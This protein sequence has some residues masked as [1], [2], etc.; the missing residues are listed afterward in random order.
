MLGKPSGGLIAISATV[1]A[2]ER[3]CGL[4]EM[5]RFEVSKNPWTVVG[6]AGPKDTVLQGQ[7][8]AQAPETSLMP[9]FSKFGGVPAEYEPCP[10]AHFEVHL[11]FWSRQA[12][13][14][15]LPAALLQG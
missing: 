6:S 10:G 9:L 7:A 11:Y 3:R 13:F 2:V 8:Q 5:S 14:R 12:W 15:L 1:L 4:N